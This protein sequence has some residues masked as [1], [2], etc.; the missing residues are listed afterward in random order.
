MKLISKAKS[1]FGRKSVSSR[2]DFFPTDGKGGYISV[3]AQCAVAELA[4]QKNQMNAYE[5]CSPLA[6]VIDRLAQGDVAGTLKIV[7]ISDGEI[8]NTPFSKRM[9]K[10]LNK[11]NPIQTW[12]QFRQQQ[13]VYKKVFGYCPIFPII[14]EGF[15][16]Y[17]YASALWN[18]PAS[19]CSIKIKQSGFYKSSI[20]DIIEYWAVMHF[21]QMAYIKPSAIFTL[22]DGVVPCQSNGGILPKSKLIGLS[23]AVANITSAMEADNTLL[24]KR[25]ALGFISKDGG[26]PDGHLPLSKNEKEDLQNGFRN[27]YGL[28]RKTWQFVISSVPVKWVPISISVRDLMTKETVKQGIELICDRL[29]YPFELLSN[30]KGVTF[31]NKA[32]AE[33]SLFQNNIIPNNIAD[34]EEYNSFFKFKENGV[35]LEMDYTKL[36]I[37]QDDEILKANAK[38]INTNTYLVQYNEGLI[39]LNEMRAGLGIETR[40]GGDKYKL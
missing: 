14:P 6:S 19:S 39:T 18:I 32:S 15:L 33:K 20:D 22:D 8:S 23:H 1:F 26:T 5:K 36:A 24:E 4:S 31:E 13:V 38:N 35:R 25:G 7:N 9:R 17:S 11:P 29:S 40:T 28:M 12:S 16:D 37:M 30:E 21:G 27:A 34:L 10:L 3:D 2:V